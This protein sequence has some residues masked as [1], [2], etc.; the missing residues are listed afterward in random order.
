MIKTEELEVLDV[1]S[2]MDEDQTTPYDLKAS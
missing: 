2:S 1:L